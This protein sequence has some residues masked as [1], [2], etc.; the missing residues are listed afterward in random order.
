MS[1]EQDNIQD[2]AY[3]LW[4]DAGSPH[5]RDQEFW[6]A[7][8]AQVRTAQPAKPK[9]P[10]KPTAAAKPKAEPKA[11]ASAKPPAK[12]PAKPKQAAKV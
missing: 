2:V 7:A 10:T 1:A 9:A 5:G 3:R 8:E 12:P 11:K 6:F 4:Q